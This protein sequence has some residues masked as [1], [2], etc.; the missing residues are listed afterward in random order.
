[1]PN[2]LVHKEDTGGI[3]PRHPILC[4][5]DLL[6]LV[7]V[8][9]M[10]RHFKPDFAVA[11]LPLIV[12]GVYAASIIYH[13]LPYNRQL[14]KADHQM[15]TLLTGLTFWSYWWVHLPTLQDPW[16]LPLM[17]VCTIVVCAFRWFW[18]KW[19]KVGGILYLWLAA[20][21][22][23]SSFNELQ[24]WL[25]SP[26]IY[27]FWLGIFFY[28]VNFLIHTLQWPDPKPAFFGYRETQHIFVLASTWLQAYVAMKYL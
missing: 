18:F 16:R 3:R 15:I 8:V 7:V 9:V 28:F 26:G 24:V 6:G 23:T 27:L 12:C 1:M 17:V 19:H 11:T 22:L 21:P 14:H 4:A 2:V 13:W 10:M 5:M 20:F 25:P